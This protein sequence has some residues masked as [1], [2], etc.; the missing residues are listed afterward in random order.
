MQ[1]SV[2]QIVEDTEAEGPGRRFA[3]WTQGCSL[4]CPGCC[5]PHLFAPGQDGVSVESLLERIAQVPGIEGITVLGGEPFDQSAPLAALCEGVRASNRSVIV[6]SGYTL[7]QLQ[8]T[9]SPDVQRALAAIDLLVDGPY[10]KD[11][12]EPSRRWVGSANQRLHAFTA[13]GRADAARFSGSNTVEIRLSG[14]SL[15]VNGWPTAERVVRR[16]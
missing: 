13:Q 2:G 11:Q 6:F 3:L 16:W 15:S 8:G 14:R 4:R 1:L 10:L 7:E 5:N 12:P 9:G